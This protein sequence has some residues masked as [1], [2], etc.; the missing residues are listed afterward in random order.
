MWASSEKFDF[1]AGP[2]SVGDVSSGNIL[3]FADG[4]GSEFARSWTDGK[5]SARIEEAMDRKLQLK[6]AMDQNM[7]QCLLSIVVHRQILISR[8]TVFLHFSKSR[9]RDIVIDRI[10]SIEL[11]SAYRNEV[12]VESVMKPEDLFSG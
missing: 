7:S 1:K 6:T 2:T 8:E 11:I 10:G 4:S 12:P 5:V 9:G 3:I